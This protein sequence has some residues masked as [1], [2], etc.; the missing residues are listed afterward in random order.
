MVK[1]HIAPSILACDFTKLGSQCQ[2]AHSCGADWL[3][4][5][6]MDGHFVPNISLGFPVIKSLRDLIPKGSGV[7]FDCHMMVSNPEQWVEELGS[8]KVDQF[9]FHYEST[10]D[11]LALIELIKKNGMKV[12]VALK[13]NTPAEV[14][15]SLGDLVDMVLVMTVEPGFGGQSFMPEMMPKVEYIRN[16]F[17]NL[18]LQVDGGLGLNTI[19]S[20][21]DAGAN[22]IV[23]GTAIFNAKEQQH[24]IDVLRQ[25][26]NDNLKKRGLLTE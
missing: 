15:D 11:P 26:V 25:K 3:H 17:N 23:A 16:K 14:V 18:N 6:V 8:I 20:A 13:P 4:L 1:A 2:H 9:T 22:V 10:K 19:D 5:D 24:V 12:G 21:A 7:F